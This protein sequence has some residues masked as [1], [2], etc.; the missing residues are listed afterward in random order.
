MGFL[1]AT[2]TALLQA[3]RIGLSDKLAGAF[4]FNAE[5]NV[6]F[7]INGEK[8]KFSQNDTMSK[9]METVNNSTKANVRLRYDETTDTFSIT[10]KQTGA[11]NNIRLKETEG[12]F[13]EAIGIDSTNP[14][15]P[16]N[17]GVDAKA[18]IDG[19]DITRNTNV[20]T[21]NGIEYTLRKE[22]TAENPQAVI[23]V[24]QNVD[25][26]VDSIKLFVEEYN[27]LIDKFST[28]LSEKQDRDYLP[29]SSEEKEALSEDEIKKWEE[30]A[31]SGILRN[32]PILSKIQSDMRMALLSA[33]EGSDTNLSSIG[34]NSKS[35]QDRGKLYIDEERLTAAI[36]ERPD[37]VKNLFIKRSES[38]PT[39]T[40]NLT[41][42]QRTDR[43]NE[44]GLFLRISDIIEDNISTFR[45]KDGRKGF[46][47][48]KA[49]IQ[50][51]LTEFGSSLSLSISDYD[52]RIADMQAALYKKEESYYLQFS[53]LETYINQMNSQM[54]WLMSQLG[55][56]G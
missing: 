40:R 25:E 27:K 21:V 12:T 5:G 43:Y 29:L 6:E 50:G 42:S 37:E 7:E 19:V 22:H 45:D 4:Y 9:V 10:A 14:I 26:V 16:E 47:L 53:R 20:F 49:G 32:D 3:V 13:F 31:K 56:F 38:V 54:N 55:A 8:F 46:L 34:I 15:K 11:G 44:Q 18:V 39:Y 17:Q 1:Q 48:E 28:T 33:V 30:R 23:T 41:Q 35:Y 36:R 2:P 51:D 52:Q 24:E